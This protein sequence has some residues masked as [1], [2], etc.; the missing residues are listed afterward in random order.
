MT[1]RAA[2]FAVF[3]AAAACGK[4]APPPPLPVSALEHATRLLS[5]QGACAT[6]IPLQWAPSFPV[7]SL[8]GGKLHYRV[9]FYGYR[10]VP[11]KELVF[12]APQG[13]AAFTPDGGVLACRAYPGE[14]VVIPHDARFKALT[15]QEIIARSSQLHSDIETV[16]AY[17]AAGRDIGE[18]GR[19]RVAAFARDFAGLADPAHAAAYRALDPDF[20][21]WVEK[22]GG[23]APAK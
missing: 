14:T 4:K 8:R 18:T 22:N 21:A 2:V 19:A 20:W 16:A 1:R 3:L 9:F 17:Y 13:E 7:P 15:L 12:H 6:V 5:A 10:R 11:G 23:S